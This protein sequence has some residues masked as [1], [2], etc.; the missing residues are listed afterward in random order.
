V[1]DVYTRARPGRYNSWGL[2]GLGIA[3]GLLAWCKIHESTLGRAADA[4]FV[5]RTCGSTLVVMLLEP[6]SN[7][8]LSMELGLH[9]TRIYSSLSV[10]S[11]R[12]FTTEP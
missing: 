2:S 5:R 4:S 7:D 1:D 6:L 10:I 3:L 12:K 8:P 9:I 11:Q